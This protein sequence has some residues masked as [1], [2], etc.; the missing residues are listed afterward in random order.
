MLPYR[1]SSIATAAAPITAVAIQPSTIRER[2]AVKAPIT[3]FFETSMMM[4]TINGT[5]TTPL[6]TALQKSAFIGHGNE[7]ATC[8]C[9][10]FLIDLKLCL[11]R[12]SRIRIS[13]RDQCSD[14]LA[15]P[16]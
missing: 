11:E 10:F 6:T 8:H 4:T 12:T 7:R 15:A 9:I 16:A 2:L 3:D 14:C 5:A 13:A 1:G